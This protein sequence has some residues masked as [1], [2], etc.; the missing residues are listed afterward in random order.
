ME[1]NA[2]WGGV[3]RDSRFKLSTHPLYPDGPLESLY[4]SNII[5]LCAREAEVSPHA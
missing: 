3:S 4:N 1:E 2:T 5:L